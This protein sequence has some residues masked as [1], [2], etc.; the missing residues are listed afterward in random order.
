M[1][2]KVVEKRE[3]KI[4]TLTFINGTLA[5]AKKKQR[6]DLTRIDTHEKK[7]NVDLYELFKIDVSVFPIILTIILITCVRLKPTKNYPF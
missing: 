7:K 3:K 1:M 2:W 5:S 4:V 6:I